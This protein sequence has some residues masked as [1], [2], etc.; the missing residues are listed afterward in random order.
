MGTYTYG[1]DTGAG[2]STFEELRFI[3]NELKLFFFLVKKDLKKRKLDF[4]WI[5]QFPISMAPW[6]TNA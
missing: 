2:F 5:R 1:K 4:V 3:K 6:T